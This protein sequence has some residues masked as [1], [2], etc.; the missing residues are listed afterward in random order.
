MN[1]FKM[2]TSM[3]RMYILIVPIGHGDIQ[4][5]SHLHVPIIRIR[6]K[7]TKISIQK[8][9]TNPSLQYVGMSSS[10]ALYAT[11]LLSPFAPSLLR[12]YL[13]PPALLPPSVS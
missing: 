6:V 4:I 11:A 10:P 3:K 9:L 12:R 1:I 7:F 13:H 2:Q 5:F 8:S